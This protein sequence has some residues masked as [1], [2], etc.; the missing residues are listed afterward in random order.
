MLTISGPGLT[1][2]IVVI[3]P[4]ILTLSNVYAGTFIGTLASEPDKASLRYTVTFDVQTRDGVKKGAYVVTY[5]KNRWTGEGFVYLPGRGDESY[6][7]NIG[8]ILRDGQDGR[9]HQ[10]SEAWSRWVCNR[11]IASLSRIS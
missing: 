6:R 10:A 9:W 2:P 4:Q 1:Q 5:S 7:R 8:T 3:D 11:T